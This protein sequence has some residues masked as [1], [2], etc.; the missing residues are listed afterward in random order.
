MK[1]EQ[2]QWTQLGMTPRLG[3]QTPASGRSCMSLVYIDDS[4]LLLLTRVFWPE[5]AYI[6]RE[7]SFREVIKNDI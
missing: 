4:T 2:K 1:N 5:H 7:F 6:F 3:I